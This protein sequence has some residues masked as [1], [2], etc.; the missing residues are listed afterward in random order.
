MLYEVLT[1]NANDSINQ[2]LFDDL[3]GSYS[4]VTLAI[5]AGAVFANNNTLT[6]PNGMSVNFFGLPGASKAVL[7]IKQIA[8]SATHSFINF[9]NV[10]ISGYVYDR[11]TSYNV[12]YTKLLRIF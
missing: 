8:L 9:T 1:L 7:S 2:T 3:A 6:I 10:D 5:P 4:T 12:C 11:I